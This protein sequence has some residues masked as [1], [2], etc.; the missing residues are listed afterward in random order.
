MTIQILKRAGFVAM[1]VFCST[2]SAEMIYQ[3]AVRNVLGDG[4]QLVVKGDS[5]DDTLGFAGDILNSGYVR[6]D[7]NSIV[8]SVS[9]SASQTSNL[10][11]GQIR[12]LG[13][14]SGFGSGPASARGLS[15]MAI[16]FS[17]DEE[18]RFTL[19]GQLR[20]AP[21][22][23]GLDLNGSSALIRLTGP[24]GVA[25]E[26]RMDDENLPDNLGVI[27]F[28]GADRMSGN[29]PAG[30]YL[31][32]AMSEGHGSD[33]ITRCADFDFTLTAV[34]AVAIPEPTTLTMCLFG[35]VSLL[36]LRRRSRG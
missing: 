15:D 36:Q 3:S 30:N 33:G 22:G 28:T 32:E 31:L 16:E 26:V 8:G 29:F 14:G 6:D 35:L 20:I 5:T 19:S 17:V 12:G 10:T 23:S 1:L 18:M 13:R 9:A 24:D 27:D 2:A 4:T 21:H 7:S 11:P 25:L 34:E